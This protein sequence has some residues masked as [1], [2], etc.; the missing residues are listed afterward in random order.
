MSFYEE[1]WGLFGSMS[2][3]ER[4]AVIQDIVKTAESEF[5]KGYFSLGEWFERYDALHLLAYC[6]AYSTRPLGPDARLP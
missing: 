3:E 5:Q 6:C 1:A 4:V 2:S